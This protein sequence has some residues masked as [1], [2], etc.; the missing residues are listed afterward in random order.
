MEVFHVIQ[1]Q[2]PEHI[3][4]VYVQRAGP[5]QQAERRD[6]SEQSEDMVT[7]KM[8]DKNMVYLTKPDPEFPQLHLGPFTAIDQKK[9]LTCI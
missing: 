4:T 8:T 3:G 7:M 1:D 2:F 9:P 6:Q 5:S